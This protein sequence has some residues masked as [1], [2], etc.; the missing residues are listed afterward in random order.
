MST[1][2]VAIVDA[3]SILYTAS[4]A[5]QEMHYR[6]EEKIFTD[7]SEAEEHGEPIKEYVELRSLEETVEHFTNLVAGIKENTGATEVHCYTGSTFGNFRKGIATIQEYKGNR[8]G[9]EPIQLNKLKEIL[10]TRGFLQRATGLLE[11]DDQVIIEFHKL[12]EKLGEDKVV[13]CVIDKD[14]KQ[15]PGNHY[16]F[17]TGEFTYLQ[18][19]D[20]L[21]FF[22]TQ[23][24]TGDPIDNILGLYKVGTKSTFVKKL[25]DLETEEDMF[26]LVY[27]EYLK[28]FGSYAEDFITETYRLL[29]MLRTPNETEGYNNVINL[30]NN[31]NERFSDDSR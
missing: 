8:S 28:R 29:Y 30:I 12:K 6:V 23:L 19:I 26:T 9:P 27:Q 24:L 13:L 14:A 15:E 7:R 21:R 4:L 11:A 18:P 10:I 17:N 3:D 25:Y 2:K 1:F 31:Y 16:N 20:S 22:Y 5:A